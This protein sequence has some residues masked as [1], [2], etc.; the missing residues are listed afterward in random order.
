[1]PENALIN[2]CRRVFKGGKRS[3]MIF[4]ITLVIICIIG[5]GFGQILLKIGMGQVGSITSFNE[6][7][8]WGT[9]IKILTN[10]YILAAFAGY[11]LIV[12]LWLGA[13]SNMNVSILF[14]L[15]SLSYVVTALAA[16][17]LL[18]ENISSMHW[19]GICLV[20]GGCVMI[21]FSKA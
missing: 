4:S 8:Q 16:W 19:A 9:L 2:Y 20:I 11:V 15:A 17:L 3:T 12:T 10:P 7:F 6:F 1:M 13:M 21:A 14:P 5:A 18:R